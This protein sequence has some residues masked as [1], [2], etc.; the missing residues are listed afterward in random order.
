MGDHTKSLVFKK[1]QNLKY[2]NYKSALKVNVYKYSCH[3]SCIKFSL[4]NSLYTLVTKKIESCIQTNTQHY[5]PTVVSI[6]PFR[7]WFCRFQDS[8]HVYLFTYLSTK[9]IF[10]PFCSSAVRNTI[11]L[12]TYTGSLRMRHKLFNTS[13]AD[14][15][16]TSPE[17]QSKLSVGDSRRLLV[18]SGYWFLVMC[19][20]CMLSAKSHYHLILTDKQIS[21]LPT[22]NLFWLL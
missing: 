15:Q 14:S 1:P 7:I 2:L 6:S 10:T 8:I 19:C 18:G 9:C 22:K 17:I 20:V 13:R 4:F 3:L 11:T 12:N 16:V 5:S 21:G